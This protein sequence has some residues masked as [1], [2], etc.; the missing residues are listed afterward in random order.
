MEQIPN[1]EKYAIIGAGP[2]GL[3]G[4]RNLQRMGIPFQG[5]EGA[6]GVGGLWDINAPQSTVYESAHLISSK[7][8]TEFTEFPMG[9]KVADFPKHTELCQYFKDFAKHFDLYQH[10]KFNTWVE[11]VEQQGDKWEITIS[12]GT[13]DT[14]AGVIIANGTLS[15][16]N[17]PEFKGTFSGEII[18]SCKYKSADI[19]ADKKVLIIGA[20]NSGCDIA[21]DAVHRAKSVDI[22]V[23]R[24][25][26]FI[27]KYVF[28]K[29]AD[30]MGGAIKLPVFLKQKIDGSLLKMFTGDPVRFGFP[31]PDHKLYE[32]HPVVNSMI[33]YHAGH[34]DITVQKD[35]DH[36]EGKSVH[37]LDGSVQ[38][39]DLILLATGYKLHYPFIDKKHLEW[40]GAAP[41]LFLNAFHPKYDN[42]FILGMV[43][44]AGIGWQGRY[45]LAELI[46]LYIKGCRD[47]NK[48]ADK[49]R[50]I[51][52]GALP[53]LS[54][55]FKYIKLDRMA[56]Y[57]HKDTYRKMVTKYIKKLT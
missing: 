28:G 31:K 12:D 3:A 53:D 37:F 1:S 51:K 34:G 54:G 46:A 7:K 36:F 9:E 44:A 49:F 17:I 25:Y 50:S 45:E 24:G 42:L 16:P 5:F 57:V 8:V 35:I 4:A 27:P 56:Y 26:H 6:S 22:S 11:K 2:A 48:N 19:F 41:K 29:P 43:E 15:E 30:T 13:K 14:Y 40:E 55:G 32:S 10:Y 38:E 23:R 33:L 47:K 20:G 39:Y 52:A 18:H 21:V